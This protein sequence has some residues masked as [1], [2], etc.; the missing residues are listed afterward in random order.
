MQTVS[1]H[2]TCG[3][4]GNRSHFEAKQARARN[5]SHAPSTSTANA[6]ERP[7]IAVNCAAIPETLSSELFGHGR[8]F[9]GANV[10][11]VG[12]FEQSRS[13][14]IFL[15]EIG[16]MSMST[17]A[18]LLRVLQG[19]TIRRLGGKDVIPSRCPCNRCDTSRP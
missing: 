16:D 19:K 9:T 13:G 1:R 7:F 10:E 2:R 18:K 11:R 12:R 17:Q 6:L 14:T 4:H 3:C 5:W 15:D 8:A